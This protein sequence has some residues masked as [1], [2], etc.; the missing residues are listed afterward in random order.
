M[1]LGSMPWPRKSDTTGYGSRW[2]RDHDDDEDT[3]YSS[4]RWRQ[5]PTMKMRGCTHCWNW[6]RFGLSYE[7]CVYVCLSP[8]VTLVH[9]IYYATNR[10]GQQR[11]TGFSSWHFVLSTRSKQIKHVQFVSTLSKKQNFVRHCWKNGNN[12]H[13]YSHKNGRIR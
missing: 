11:R 7:L 1:A 2:L 8:S 13:V 4:W 9:C 3:L 6:L 12:D 10:F 5:K